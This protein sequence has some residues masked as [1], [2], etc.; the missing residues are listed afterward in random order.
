MV[1]VAQVSDA[2]A[3]RPHPTRG[4]WFL[5]KRV[6]K[7]H[8]YLL[9]PS[10]ASPVPGPRIQT[11]SY[12]GP[13]HAVDHTATFVA[14]LVPHPHAA[15]LMVWVNVWS[16]VNAHRS[17]QGVNFCHCVPADERQQWY[18]AGWEDRFNF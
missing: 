2:M 3:L 16:S 8:C 18:A 12:V 10:D 6:L 13:V 4:D 9:P 5:T 11:A 7:G 1:N 15:D 17:P 14:V